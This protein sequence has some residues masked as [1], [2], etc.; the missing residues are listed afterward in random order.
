[1]KERKPQEGLK[2][3]T[4]ESFDQIVQKSLKDPELFEAMRKDFDKA[5]AS[6]GYYIEKEFSE[7]M[8][9]KAAD[10]LAKQLSKE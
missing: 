6:Q 5:L 7:A 8:R 4:E 3:L 2:P 10:L 9:N 1:M